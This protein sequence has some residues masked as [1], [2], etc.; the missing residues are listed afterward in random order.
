MLHIGQLHFGLRPSL[1]TIR[2]CRDNV[3]LK[4]RMQI[5]KGAMMILFPFIFTLSD[6]EKKN[7]CYD[8]STFGQRRVTSGG[9]A[10]W[11]YLY[12]CRFHCCGSAFP[13]VRLFA[14]RLFCSSERDFQQQTNFEDPA[15]PSRAHSLLRVIPGSQIQG[16]RL[17]SEHVCNSNFWPDPFGN[18]ASPGQHT[19]PLPCSKMDNEAGHIYARQMQ[20]VSRSCPFLIWVSY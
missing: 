4:E 14:T 20:V 15:A 9:R 16:K 8:L 10:S 1:A 6:D 5:M 18:K 12:L 17:K 3:G 13:F 7:P 11:W 2:H 19:C